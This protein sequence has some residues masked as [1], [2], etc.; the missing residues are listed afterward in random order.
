[1]L[2]LIID[3]MTCINAMENC[4]AEDKKRRV[5]DAI[6]SVKAI[7]FRLQKKLFDIES[8]APGPLQE[9]VNPKK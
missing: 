5:K 6:E 2:D 3:L 9:F 7:E 8:A 4:H 1:M